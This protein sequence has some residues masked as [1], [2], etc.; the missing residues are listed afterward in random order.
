[1][2]SPFVRRTRLWT[3]LAAT[4]IA[5]LAFAISQ[6]GPQAN[7]QQDDDG[8]VLRIGWV[9]GPETLNPFVAQDTLA[10][11][12]HSKNWDYL[13]NFSAEDNTPVPGIAESWKVSSDRRSVT[14]RLRADDEW[15][16]GQPITSADVKYSLEV[17]GRNGVIFGSYVDNLRAVETPDRRTVIVRTR[18]P[19]ARVVGGLLVPIVPAHAWREHSV[20]ELTGSFTPDLPLVGSGPWVVTKFEQSKLVELERNPR[21]RG[22]RPRLREAPVHRL[23]VPGRGVPRARAR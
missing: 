16:D 23:R 3:G 1:M 21:F 18:I 8:D 11:T 5:V 15:S 7:A 13:V 4:L 9:D 12:I 17:L 10:A 14:F 22:E 19:D 6:I 2:D 20:K